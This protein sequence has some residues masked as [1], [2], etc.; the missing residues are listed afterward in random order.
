MKTGSTN[1]DTR[2]HGW[3]L[4]VT[5]ILVFTAMAATVGL[6]V[7]ALPDSLTSL[8]TPC[9]APVNQ[10]L[11]GSAQ[12]APLARLGITPQTLAPVAIALSC[13]TLF[14]AEGAAAVLLWRRS[15]DWIALLVALTL[16]LAPMDLTPVLS[17]LQARPG[18]LQAP[19]GLLGA[20]SS[21][22]ILLLLVLFPSGRFV[23]RW[24]WIPSLLLVLTQIPALEAFLPL[25][26]EIGALLQLVL[27]LCIGASQIYR[28]RWVSTKVERQQTKWV[29]YGFILLIGVNQLFWLPYV[30]IPTLHQPDSLYILL[31][32]PDDFFMLSLVVVTLS[33]AVLR[34]RLWDIDALINK[35]LVYG[36]LTS[37]LGTLYACLV[38]GLSTLVGAING[39]A[40]GQPVVLVISTL[41][42]ATLFQPVRMRIQT[43]IDR[44]FYR[45]KYDTEK[46]LAAL[47]TALRNEVDLSHIHE[48]LLAVVQETMQPTSLSLWIFS[49]KQRVSEEE[50]RGEALSRGEDR[51]NREGF[52]SS[53]T[54][55]FSGSVNVHKTRLF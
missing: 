9:A 26:E 12:V 50:T 34:H 31:A 37:L 3:P 17:L 35:T 54:D 44:R 24:L 49:M 43:L 11:I 16:I 13:L 27:I 47:S 2:L 39:Q 45:Q 18:I 53:S 33:V 5:R 36:A 6:F 38:I 10:C 23:P 41:L 51:L 40:V 20:A 46:A 52:N 22:A 28:Y 15:N 32:Y 30:L 14:L 25:P 48:H 19:A 4:V 55:L 8:A 29:M 21:L 7:L 42:I 1:S